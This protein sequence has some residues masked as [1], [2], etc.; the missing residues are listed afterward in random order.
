MVFLALGDVARIQTWVL[1][2]VHVRMDGFQG[3]P[4]AEIAR[5]L[6]SAVT[7]LACHARI[8]LRTAS[9]VLATQVDRTGVG[10]R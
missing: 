1:E 8:P 6:G 9:V 10:I 3:W 2:L 4:A 7:C 5:Y